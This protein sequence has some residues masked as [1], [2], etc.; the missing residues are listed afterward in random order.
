M[1]NMKDYLMLPSGKNKTN[2]F[3]TYQKQAKCF[4]KRITSLFLLNYEN[5][6]FFDE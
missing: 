3:F 2:L 5:E 4:A 6:S 1:K